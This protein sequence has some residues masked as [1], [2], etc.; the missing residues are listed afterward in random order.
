MQALACY[1]AYFG[2]L[3]RT[4]PMSYVTQLRP[5]PGAEDGEQPSRAGSVRVHRPR[6][7]FDDIQGNEAIKARLKDAARKIVAARPEKEAPRNGIILFGEPG[8]GKTIFAEALAG[9]LDLPLVTVTYSDVA[10]KWVGA[11]TEG[12]RDAFDHA[13]ACQPSVLFI[14]EIDSFITDRTGASLGVKEDY[15][16]TNAM[17]T[18]LVDIRRHKVVLVAA[19]NHI[20]RLDTAAVREG[21]FDF[22]VEIT[23]PDEAART[24]LLRKGLADHLPAVKVDDDVLE[25][26]SS[27]WNGFSVKRILAVTEELPSYLEAVG[28]SKPEFGDFMGAL[29]QL[30]G[31]RGFTP[32]NTKPL[33]DLVFSLRTRRALESIVGRMSDPEYTERRGGTLPTGVLFMGQPGTGKTAAC[34]AL[35]KDI[36]WAYLPTVGADIARDPKRLDALYAKAKDLRPTVVFIDEAD[37]LLRDRAFSNATEATNKLLTLMD[38]VGDRV[39]DVVWIAATNLPDQIDAALLRGGRFGEKVIFDLPSASD[40]TSYIS[41]WCEEKA[42]ALEPGSSPEVMARLFGES[43]IA[44]AEAILQAALNRAIGRREPQLTVKFS[45]VQEAVSLIQGDN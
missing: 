38:G 8:N 3:R 43:S 18:M 14:D 12:L 17:L 6:L 21:R 27:R 24:G 32:E 33:S 42:I 36:G 37:E 28:H 4:R 25:R 22:K 44:N 9:E 15:D 20:D 1:L 39:R 16:I 13:I 10:S 7:T 29:R 30:Q 31:Q 35:A 2:Y 45:D 5:F 34:K 41:A 23:P 19:T 26:V 11:K 40:L